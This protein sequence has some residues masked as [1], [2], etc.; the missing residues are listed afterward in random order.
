MALG[1]REV[2]RCSAGDA[3]QAQPPVSESRLLH[4]PGLLLLLHCSGHCIVEC[5]AP[6]CR[7]LV[8]LPGGILCLSPVCTLGLCLQQR[9]LREEEVD[10]SGSMRKC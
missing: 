4:L 1:Q 5:L 8:K 2:C 6:P 3:K 7:L 10:V 9:S